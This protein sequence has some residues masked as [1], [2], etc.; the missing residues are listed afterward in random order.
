MLKYTEEL[1]MKRLNI[2]VPTPFHEDERLHLEGFAPIVHHLA[3]QGIESLLICGSTG[4]QHAL[5]IDERIEIIQYFN[6]RRFSGVELIC[7]ISSVRTRDALRLIQAVEGSVFDA[8]MIGFPPYVLPTQQQA[9]HYVDELLRHTTKQVML[10]NN[11]P[12]TGFDLSAESFRQLVLRHPNIAGFKEVGD[13]ERHKDTPLPDSFIMF[14][15]GD[16]DFPAKINHGFNGLSSIAGNMHPQEIKEALQALLEGSPVD[17]KQINT[18]IAE[19]LQ[20][21]GVVRVKQF[22]QQ[23]GFI[24]AVCRSPIGAV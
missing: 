23:L 15:A 5:T 1:H 22:Y 24:S 2:A 21:Q 17:H 11:P 18:L 6:S 20:G 9:V 3:G 19:A 8:V 13:M 4:E 10:Y 14:T 16:R 7:G 12:R